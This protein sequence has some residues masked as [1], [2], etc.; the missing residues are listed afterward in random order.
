[1]F[2]GEEQSTGFFC[3][4]TFSCE[5]NEA[6]DVRIKLQGAS[7]DF[8]VSVMQAPDGQLIDPDLAQQILVLIREYAA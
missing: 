2:T 1:V 4:L 7:Q 5:N 3:R 6:L 8:S